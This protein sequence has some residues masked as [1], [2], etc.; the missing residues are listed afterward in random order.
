MLPVPVATVFTLV[1]KNWME[2]LGVAWNACIC[3]S[4][5]AGN[6]SVELATSCDVVVPV[7]YTLPCASIVIPLAV[8]VPVPERY[9]EYVSTD[10]GAGDGPLFNSVTNTCVVPVLPDRGTV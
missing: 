9:V 6:W 4:V 8:S 1:T 2:D 7:T 5:L 10:A 3:G